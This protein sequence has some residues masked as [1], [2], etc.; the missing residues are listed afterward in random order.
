M[1]IQSKEIHYTL[2]H[3]IE[4]LA[5]SEQELIKVARL[6]SEK[7]YAP[8]SKFKVGASVLL[9]NHQIISANNQENASYP[10]GL[11]AERVALFYA[12]AQYPN[13]KISALA[14]AGNANSENQYKP[15]TP[16]GACR[17][18]LAE[19]ESKQQEKIKIFMTGMNGKIMMVDGIDNLLPF[20]FEL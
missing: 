15:I 10:E 20:R 12:S 13:E 2:F 16:C 19:Y 1:S 5:E 4:E 9:S 11:C 7:A 8:Y 17:Q 3:S 6:S 14:I 18:V